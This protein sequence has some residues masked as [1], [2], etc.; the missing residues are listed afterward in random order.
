MQLPTDC[1]ANF[2]QISRMSPGHAAWNNTEAP[3]DRA[4]VHVLASDDRGSYVIPFPVVF[5][6]DNWFNLYTGQMISDDVYVE[7]WLPWPEPIYD[8]AKVS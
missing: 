5:R 8:A 3:Q 4:I 1:S 6:D 2:H 7:G